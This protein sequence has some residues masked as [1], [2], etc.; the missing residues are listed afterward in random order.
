LVREFTPSVADFFCGGGGLSE[1]FRQAGFKVLFG[2]DS[3]P[4]SVKTYRKHHGKAIECKVEDFTIDMILREIGSQDITVLAAGPPCTAFSTVAVAKLRSIGR[5]AN[6]R[7][8]INNLYKSFLRLVKEIEPPF[9][10]MENVHRMFTISGGVVKK[11]IEQ[12][13]GGKYNLTFYYEHMADF[14]VPQQR[15]RGLVI[16]NRLGIPNPILEQTHYDPK[17]KMNPSGKK[18]YVTV[19][20]AISDLPRIQAG[21]GVKL[22]SYP[23]RKMLSG[24]QIEKRKDSDSVLHHLARNHNER[25]LA[26]FK[27]LKPGKW[28]SD[29]PEKYN[30]YRKDIF[31]DKYKKQPWNRPSSTILAH[32]SKDGLMFIHPDRK[33]N[34]SFTPREAARL[35]SFDD[36]YT[37]E[38]PRTQQFKQIGNA[39]P[40]L[41]AKKI[42]A[43]ILDTMTIQIKQN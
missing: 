6:M 13:L 24:Y 26:I 31:L 28:I 40:P 30:P 37:F 4:W 34:R 35:Q 18:Q 32:L 21:K 5:S 42:A 17:G 41:F 14:G 1:G 3:D 36:K 27:M 8:P 25:D 11:D 23:R 19:R 39:V 22:T 38:G 16:G 9:L 29:L 33:Q 12:Y 7:N 2:V 43:S 15:K 20:S 10:V